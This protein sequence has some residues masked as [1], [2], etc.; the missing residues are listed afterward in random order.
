MEEAGK[1]TKNPTGSGLGKAGAR[2]LGQLLKRAIQSPEPEDPKGR[3]KES[4]PKTPLRLFKHQI[5]TQT[6]GG[7]KK[8][9]TKLA[10]PEVS[11]VIHGVVSQCKRRGSIS[12][13]QLKQTLA[14]EG[15]DVTKSNRQVKATTIRLVKR[16]TFVRTTRS[17]SL[18][19][20]KKILTD[21]RRNPVK[22]PKPKEEKMTLRSR[23]QTQK[24]KGKTHTGASGSNNQRGKTPKPEQKQASKL[25][26]TAI[27]VQKHAKIK[28]AQAKKTL[29]KRKLY[30]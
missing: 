26:K 5:Q 24:P 21:K 14:A 16:E 27:K 11:K 23:G 2:R 4:L 19:L 18:R 1:S 8:D 17:A 30:R 12:M 15:Y 7:T 9:S 28:A 20:N 29:R 22:S 3:R 6:K 25:R 13:A 10:L